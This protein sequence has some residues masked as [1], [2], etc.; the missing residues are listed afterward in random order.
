MEI[1][2]EGQWYDLRRA[3]PLPTTL[4]VIVIVNDTVTVKV[5][6][7]YVRAYA[8]GHARAIVLIR[9]RPTAGLPWPLK[10]LIT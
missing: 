8:G 2:G 5:N 7:I 6:S 9:H 4:S 10:L 1:L 3:L